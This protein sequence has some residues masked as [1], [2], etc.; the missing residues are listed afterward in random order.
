[1]VILKSGVIC[2]VLL[3]P[4]A[5]HLLNE[6]R[7]ELIVPDTVQRCCDVKPFAIQ[8]QL[9]HLRSSLNSLPLHVTGLR[10]CSQFRILNYLH[11]SITDDAASNKYLIRK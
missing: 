4:N 5:L 1:M 3:Y 11:W 10:L 6:V 7:I 8:T 9:N 2:E